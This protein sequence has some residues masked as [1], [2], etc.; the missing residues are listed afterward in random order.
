[1]NSKT[2]NKT[3]RNCY[4][5]V[6]H[7]LIVLISTICYLNK[8]HKKYTQKTILYYFNENL[9][10]NGQTI[11][12]LRTMQKYIYRLQKEI[13][14]T[15]NYYQHMGV[16]SGTEIY[17]KLNY[18]KKDCYHKINQHFKEKKE[19][20]YQNRVANYFNKNSDSK[21]GSVQLGECN[22]NNNNIKE[23]RKIN[24]IE[25]YQVIKYFNKCD[26]SCKEILPVLLTLNIDKENII[27]IIKILKITEINSKNKNIRPTKS[28]IKKKQE[29]LKGILCNTQ[30]EL[31]ENGYNS[32]QLEINFQKIYENYKY[33]PH[34]IIENHKYSDLNN[35]KRKLEKSIERKKENSQQDYENLKI[36][37]FNILIEQLKKETNIEILKPI[38]KEYLNNQKKIKYNKIFGIYY[39]EL[40]EIIKNRKHDLNLE[41]FS[42]KVV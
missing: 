23:E 35:I 8:T 41:K 22:N 42:K 18:P 4:N 12:T 15:T 2:T 19:E 33:K 37:V 27:K 32:K 16:N 21:M 38:I 34:F 3:N 36:N 7:K 29:K 11:S 25:K 5:K 28:C 6:Q 26:F 13:K 14:V 31:E 39:L 24:E 40:L 30:K 9:R 1:M 17:Y 10:K 20:R